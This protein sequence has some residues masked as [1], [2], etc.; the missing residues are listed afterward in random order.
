MRCLCAQSGSAHTAM[1]AH[2]SP[3]E[4][5]M[6]HRASYVVIE[7]GTTSIYYSHWGAKSI[8]STVLAGPTRTLAFMRSLTPGD[9]LLNNIWCEGGLLVDA[10]QGHMLF[11]GGE[12]VK[13][14]PHVRRVFL[15]GLAR[16]W[17]GW[18]IQ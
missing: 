6:G 16:L 7:Q 14:C 8:P 17:A 4:A 10:D 12:A 18:T 5:M 3:G 13:Y 2:R 11:W 9:H 1:A 15:P